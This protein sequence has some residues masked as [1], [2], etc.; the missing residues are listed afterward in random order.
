MSE[1]RSY[2]HGRARVL[3]YLLVHPSSTADAVGAALGIGAEQA[4]RMMRDAGCRRTR[5]RPP[6]WSAPSAPPSDVAWWPAEASHGCGMPGCTAQ[7]TRTWR[8]G[9]W[10]AH[11]CEQ[12]EVSAEASEALALATRAECAAELARLL[13]RRR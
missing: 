13:G 7:A 4:R 3:A 1:D 9:S 11:R 6:R 10:L 2:R 8:V 12:H 5:H